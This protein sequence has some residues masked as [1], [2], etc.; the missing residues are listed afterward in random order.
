MSARFEIFTATPIVLS[1]WSPPP[2]ALGH[3]QTI[4]GAIDAAK[5]LSVVEGCRVVVHDK[6]K[7][8]EFATRGYAESARWRWVKRCPKCDGRGITVNAGGV[9][10]A[11]GRCDRF[12][13]VPEESRA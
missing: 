5:R 12:G 11:C 9:G 7:V 4:D 3:M 6:A 2:R 10:A 8:G 1:M 13:Y